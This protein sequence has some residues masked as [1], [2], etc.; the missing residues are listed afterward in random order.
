MIVLTATC[1][2]GAIALNKSLP[3]ELED[4]EIEIIV[5]EISTAKGLPK[6]HRQSGS[7][8]GLTWMCPDFDQPL[9]DLQEYM[10]ISC[11]TIDL[12]NKLSL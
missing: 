8:K 4:K 9:E 5:R 1:K 2:N 10:T 6:K 11:I 12:E 7:A 3:N